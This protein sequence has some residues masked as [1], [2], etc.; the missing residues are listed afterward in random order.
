MASTKTIAL[1]IALN[2]E[3][4]F[5]AAMRAAKKETNLLGTEMKDL[6]EKYKSNANTMEALQAKQLKLS[7]AQEAYTKRVKAAE[8][9]LKNAKQNERDHAKQL[10]ELRNKLD[11]AREALEKVEKEQ[12]K[13]SE[14]YKEQTVLV[15]K[16]TEE[17]KEHTEIQAKAENAVST[18][19]KELRNANAGLEE[20]NKEIQE[21]DRYL[22]EARQS[23][24][25]C[26][27]SIDEYG[28][29]VGEAAEESAKLNISLS[30]MVKNKLIDMAG[31]ALRNLGQKAIEAAKYVVEVGSSFEAQMDKV[32]AISG[33]TGGDL[34]ALTR[35]AQEMGASTKFTATQA[36]EALEYMAMAG[37]K[38][39]DM[40]D[41]LEG[42]MYLAAASGEDLGTTSD[43]VTDA[44]TAFGL[45]AED[46]GHFAD[47]LAAA[48]SSANT[49]VSM[50]GETFKYAA[51][52]AGAYGFS[53]EDTAEAIGLMANSGIKASQ[54]GTSLRRI[55]T[56]MAGPIEIAGENLGTV[57]VETAN[58]DG[59]M[60][61]LGDILADC[62]KAF[63][64][65]SEAE[66]VGAAE[67]IAGKN[68]MSGFL[69]L[70]NAAPE[71]IAKLE[72]ALA[73]CDG[74]AEEM[75]ETMQ[76][77]LAGKLEIFKSAVEGL[78]LALY[79]MI[80][81]PLQSVVYF[82]TGVVGGLTKL[83]APP[84]T[85]LEQFISDIDYANKQVEDSIEHARSTVENAELKKAEIETAKTFLSDLLNGCGEFN[86]IDLGEGRYQILDATG[87]IIAEGFEPVTTAVDSANDAL[88]G[89]G[90]EGIG[91]TPAIFEQMDAVVTYFDDAG[92]HVETFKTD[93]SETGNVQI[94]T[95]GLGIEEGT[96]RIV[97][98]FN[99]AGDKIGKFEG[100]IDELG[101]IQIDM[102][103]TE[104]SLESLLSM[105]SEDKL[106]T[107][108]QAIENAGNVTI[109]TEGVAAGTAAI[110]QCFTDAGEKVADYQTEVD[111]AGNVVLKTDEITEPVTVLVTA[112][113]EGSGTVREFRTRLD[114]MGKPV[115]VTPII[116][117]LKEISDPVLVIRDELTK[118][119]VD[120][121][122]K[123][124]GD[125]IEGLDEAWDSSTGTIRGNK[126]EILSW[127]DAAQ[128][129]AMQDALQSAMTELYSARAD[130]LINVAKAQ[131]GVNK[132]VEEFNKE[133][134]TE[135]KTWE[136]LQ[137]GTGA[138]YDRFDKA[139]QAVLAAKL[140]LDE[141]EATFKSTSAELT[142]TGEALGGLTDAYFQ[143]GE[144][145]GAA[146]EAVSSTG[147]Y[148]EDAAAAAKGM[149]ESEEDAAAATDTLTEATD[150]LTE[151]QQESIDTYAKL[152][153]V[154]PEGLED[155]Q[156]AFAAA[157]EDFPEWC[158]NRVKE[159]KEI[160]EAYDD[161]TGKVTDS[162]EAMVTELNA[163]DEEGNKSLSN[164]LQHL[165][166]QAQKAMEWSS[167]MQTLAQAVGEG[168]SQNLYDSL[169][170]QGPE[171]AAENVALLAE[172]YRNGSGEFWEI[173]QE[174]ENNI[175]S[176]ISQ[177][178]AVAQFSSAAA[179]AHNAF[180]D[181]LAGLPESVAET[182][183]QTGSAVTENGP[184]ISEAMGAV[185]EETE[186]T[187]STKAQ[188][189]GDAGAQAT[190]AM[191]GAIEQGKGEVSQATEEMANEAKDAASNIAAQFDVAG[192]LAPQQFA[193]GMKQQKSSAVTAAD[194]MGKESADAVTNHQSDFVNAGSESA[195]QYGAGISHV[196]SVA[197]NA[198]GDMANDAANAAG[199]SV[200]GFH[201]SGANAAIGFANG[202]NANAGTAVNAAVNMAVS[203]LNAANA[204]LGVS[205]PA[206]ETIK[207]GR[208]FTEG[209]AIGILERKKLSDEA[210]EKVASSAAQKLRDRLER[211]TGSVGNAAKQISKTISDELSRVRIQAGP[212]ETIA[213][214]TDKA[215]QAI[216][217]MARGVSDSASKMEDS[218]SKT[219]K[220]ADSATA[221]VAR[222]KGVQFVS[223][224][225]TFVGEDAEAFTSD[226]PEQAQP[227]D[228]SSVRS[229]L[230]EDAQKT[231][232]AMEIYTARA[233]NLLR[234]ADVKTKLSEKY[235][236]LAAKF[237]AQKIQANDDISSAMAAMR[238]QA[239]TASR[240]RL[241]DE[242]RT[243]VDTYRN[244]SAEE[245]EREISKL[246]ESKN[247][248]SSAGYSNTTALSSLPSLTDGA[249]QT[250]KES[251]NKTMEAVSSIRALTSGIRSKLDDISRAV[252][253]G[254]TIK[255]TAYFGDKEVKDI[256]VKAVRDTINNEM[257]AA[258][259]A[260]GR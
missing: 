22:E 58:A 45:K 80:S 99:T 185:W 196:Q 49:N 40:L 187:A 168:W 94:P 39:E 183:N 70:M 237:Q 51:P 30:D 125:S 110:V 140:Q 66:K 256:T 78:S 199:N 205:S 230:E 3:K 217:T 232:A 68:A 1:K 56:E 147:V 52:L 37:W 254:A 166:E 202:I 233:Q 14:A 150:K 107:F 188:E 234:L 181:G 79:N 73:S 17:V 54:A 117:S 6:Q 131:A 207:T 91:D 55:F 169:L 184:M 108:R 198:A 67:T 251:M 115:D 83:I 11:D 193:K 156:A 112:V 27:H 42:V 15:D 177:G 149:T 86:R 105:F 173:G 152:F 162:L 226:A 20:I 238:S 21:N 61:N 33:A 191:A 82:F 255:M 178:N 167:N 223:G 84:K 138:L 190:A 19:R 57:T 36:G 74:K 148:V 44:L 239:A 46:S 118:S 135:F 133:N 228:T 122:V 204:A 121:I 10:E 258:K 210:A 260:K 120:A 5:L 201:N 171:K 128:E 90:S 64:G 242:L 259:V 203:A 63:S 9:G 175:V 26:A 209:Q 221:A 174:Y 144:A 50:M 62:R 113:E 72:G 243:A 25:G 88:E 109:Q 151:K 180:A 172:G 253:K 100:K 81:G 224:E 142:S 240:Y 229:S 127:I 197:A 123:A 158:E 134:G 129:A 236:K 111:N 179:E 31:D 77:N 59:T 159:A 153:E 96:E 93:V 157:G 124:L 154:A 213:D 4:E 95:S 182:M 24:D 222:A 241:A 163:A 186:A 7:E 38:T 98:L 103:G 194:G 249:L 231:R 247:K 246:T 104:S 48:S 141:C 114:E 145:A 215:E 139:G 130:A 23:A 214:G 212:W 146:G 28:K 12:G 76:D 43:I 101:N 102:S 8:E 89:F 116:D 106:L 29:E 137:E 160:I 216:R 60:R 41:G 164:M 189:T 208:F 32:S 65:L 235:E 206:K 53:I 13:G 220:A 195:K 85:E 227:I 170:Q 2:G 248:K 200:I 47:V 155:L 250:L 143:T 176:A 257:R 34:D 16:L 211:E 218:L 245:V 192:Q 244:T 71:D 75:S 219:K 87:A 252:E 165:R 136:E 132:A 126:E 18:W 35:K 225:V 119:K 92:K 69:A 97:E 161:L